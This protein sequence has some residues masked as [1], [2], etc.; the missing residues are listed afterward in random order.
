[1]SHFY[2]SASKQAQQ[3]CSRPVTKFAESMQ[4]TPFPS[5]LLHSLDSSSLL[6]L[7]RLHLHAQPHTW[8]IYSPS[9]ALL[10]RRSLLHTAAI[11]VLVCVLLI[12]FM[13][14]L[15]RPSCPHRFPFYIRRG[16]TN[17]QNTGTY[18]AFF[19]QREHEK[20]FCSLPDVSRLAFFSQKFKAGSK[21]LKSI[22]MHAFCRAPQPLEL[23]HDI[24]KFSTF[25]QVQEVHPSVKPV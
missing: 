15:Q 13:L 10:Y 4:T 17:I 5:T 14:Y 6:W 21:L 1:M 19:N 12:Y 22:I 8:I 9:V 23:K 7:L 24:I 20:D 3:Q 2:C 18:F 11:V 16:Q 25:L